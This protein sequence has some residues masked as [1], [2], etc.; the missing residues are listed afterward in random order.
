MY[1]EARAIT[2]REQVLLFQFEPDPAESFEEV[3]GLRVEHL[4][5]VAEFDAAC[6]SVDAR[7]QVAELV[8]CATDQSD[9]VFG[10]SV[11]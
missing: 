10:H 2:E 4:A 3:E 7:R 9:A 5:A 1:V 11:P 8:F 6:S